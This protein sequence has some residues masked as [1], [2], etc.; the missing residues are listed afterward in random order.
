MFPKVVV[1]VLIR[2]LQTDVINGNT[3][4][5]G[6]EVFTI[7]NSRVQEIT[8]FESSCEGVGFWAKGEN[9][10]VQAPVRNRGRGWVE[11]IGISRT[12]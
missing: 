5:W 2:E 10:P 12:D 8:S 3:A 1:L 9:F 11:A 6:I 4:L 7:G